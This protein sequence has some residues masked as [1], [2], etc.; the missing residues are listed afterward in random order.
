MFFLQTALKDI[1]SPQVE[2]LGPLHGGFPLLVL[3]GGKKFRR[4]L[5][6]FYVLALASLPDTMGGDL[7]RVETH[8]KRS[9]EKS[10]GLLAGPYVSYAQAVAVPAHDYAAFKQCLETALALDVD[11]DPP[12]RLV[13]IIS[14]RKARALLENVDN[15]FIVMDDEGYE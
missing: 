2:Q 3:D 13:N 4:A 8:F 5:D 6:D 10:G 15:F 14:Q 11:A 12:N 9:L 1:P 7:S